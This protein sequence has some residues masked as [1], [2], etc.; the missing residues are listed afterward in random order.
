MNIEKGGKQEVS[1]TSQESFW[2]RDYEEKINYW[3]LSEGQLR[4]IIEK[5]PE[6]SKILEIGC[7]DGKLLEQLKNNDKNFDLYGSDI[8]IDH[9]RDIE[10]RISG[11]KTFKLDITSQELPK[12]FDTIIMKFVLG[13]L[14]SKE[15]KSQEELWDRVLEKIKNN[16]DYFILITPVLKQGIEQGKARPIFIPKDIL[17][18]LLDKHFNKKELV[19][20]QEGRR[21][22]DYEIYFL[23]KT[24]QDAP[25]NH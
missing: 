20:V 24:E 12:K 16:C 15:Y 5:L 10:K 13:C 2:R 14:R 1:D 21:N 23:E 22:F 7:G 3:Q 25:S 6:K 18:K 11:I 9:L 17:E 4:K 8:I 19:D